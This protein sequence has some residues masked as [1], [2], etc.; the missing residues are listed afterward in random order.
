MS[1]TTINANHSCLDLTIIVENYANLLP[2]FMFQS[3]FHVAIKFD[4]YCCIC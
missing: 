2:V 3:V 4:L 1:F